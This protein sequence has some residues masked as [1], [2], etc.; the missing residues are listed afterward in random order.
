M[1]WTRREPIQR[2]PTNL[3]YES[4]Q[5]QSGRKP[6]PSVRFYGALSR[7][8]L[9]SVIVQLAWHTSRVYQGELPNVSEAMAR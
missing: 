8:M 4:N 9:R 7:D 3:P 2:E 1:K 6:E 5:T